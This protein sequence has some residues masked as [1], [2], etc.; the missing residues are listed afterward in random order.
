MAA[1][2]IHVFAK[3]KAKDGYLATVLT[4][5]KEVRSKTVRENGNL[6]YKIHQGQEDVNTLIL[7]EGYA[8]R[9]AQQD[10]MNADHFKKLVIE[11]IVP[12]LEEREVTLTIPLED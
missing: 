1:H 3:W 2:P 5:L 10:H 7:F 11:Q 4:L 9:E 12:L 6:F 8:S